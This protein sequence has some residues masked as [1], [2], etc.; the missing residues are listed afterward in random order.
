MIK[1]I[2]FYN[3]TVR[4]PVTQL[5]L[6]QYLERLERFWKLSKLNRMSICNS[7]R[8]CIIY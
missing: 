3:Q 6:L 4:H 1:S 7:F 8:G 2:K 5:Q